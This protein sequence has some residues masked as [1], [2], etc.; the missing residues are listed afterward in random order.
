MVRGFS[1]FGVG[2]LAWIPLMLSGWFT[3]TT[4]CSV[5]GPLYFFLARFCES[6]RFASLPI[7]P[8]RENQISDAEVALPR[9]HALDTLPGMILPR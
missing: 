9:T 4:I 6:P 2:A 3:V 1:T 8:D 5:L 7:G